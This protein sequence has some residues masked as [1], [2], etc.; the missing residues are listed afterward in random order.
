MLIAATINYLLRKYWKIMKKNTSLDIKFL[1]KVIFLHNDLWVINLY[2]WIPNTFWKIKCKQFTNITKQN[3][4]TKK[5]K[6]TIWR[7]TEA[8]LYFL[9]PWAFFVISKSISFPLLK[10]FV[11]HCWE[12]IISIKICFM[13]LQINILVQFSL[14]GSEYSKEKN[15]WEQWHNSLS[16]SDST[17]WIISNQNLLHPENYENKFILLFLIR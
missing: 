17:C 12:Y 10:V 16:N 9:T 3:K 4:Q 8:C 15:S 5:P 11:A 7:T 1:F 2:I 6:R 13:M 14:M